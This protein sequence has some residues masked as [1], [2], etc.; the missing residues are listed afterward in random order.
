M[1]KAIQSSATALTGHARLK[2]YLQLPTGSNPRTQAL[3]EQLLAE[4][5]SPPHTDISTHDLIAAALLRLKTGGY[6]ARWS[7]AW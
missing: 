5:R 2:R 1:R 4:L 6:T 3:G 7:L